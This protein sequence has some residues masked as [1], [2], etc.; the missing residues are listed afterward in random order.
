MKKQQKDIALFA[1]RLQQLRKQRGWS[2]PELGKQ[3]GVSGQIIG[4]YELG[5]ISPSIEVAR[6]LARV[7]GVTVDYLIG[8]EEMLDTL[9]DRQMLT[10]WQDMEALSPEDKDHILYIIDSFLRDAKAREAYKVN[11]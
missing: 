10:R 9:K 4:R 8:E 2:Q 6:R 3:T 5:L 7:F 1:K 11:S